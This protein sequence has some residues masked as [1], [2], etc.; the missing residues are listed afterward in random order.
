MQLSSYSQT[1]IPGCGSQEECFKAAENSF[2]T[3]GD[4]GKFFHPLNTSLVEWL[5]YTARSWLYL[6]NAKNALHKINSICSSAE[7]NYSELPDLAN[8]FNAYLLQ[9]ASDIDNANRIAIAVLYSQ[10]KAFEAN[11]IKLMQEEPL[12]KDFTYFQS[13]LNHLA[14]GKQAENNF[15]SVYVNNAEKFQGLVAGTGFRQ[16]YASE[17]SFS[18]LFPQFSSGILGSMD[19]GA[20]IFPFIRS[21]L[22]GF[23]GFVYSSN[24][25]DESLE[26]MKKAP[27]F[28][29]F[30]AMDALA[31]TGNS[32]A[33]E[34]ASAIKS[35]ALNIKS[36]NEKAGS[37]ESGITESISSI[38][39]SLSL[40][41]INEG[42]FD[43]AFVSFLFEGVQEEST[44]GLQGFK[45]NSLP[46]LKE[47]LQ[48]ELKNIEKEFN[49]LREEDASGSLSLGRKLSGFKRIQSELDALAKNVSFASNGLSDG[50][51]GLCESKSSMIKAS[52]PDVNAG[53]IQLLY[54]KQALQKKL[55]QFDSAVESNKLGSCREFATAFSSLEKASKDFLVFRQESE[56]QADD[57]IGFLEKVFSAADASFLNQDF[58]ALKADESLF[59]RPFAFNEGC[60]ELKEKTV[61]FLSSKESVKQLE[62]G[63]LKAKALFASMNL[64]IESGEADSFS[65]LKEFFPDGSFDLSNYSRI[66]SVSQLLALF[67]EKLSLKA[68]SLIGK[69]PG[70]IKAVQAD[71]GNGV[72]GSG[73]DFFLEIMNPFKAVEEQFT[74]KV[75]F[76]LNAKLL[77]KPDYVS[78]FEAC[79]KSCLEGG[80]SSQEQE[81]ECLPV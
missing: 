57:C 6:N 61:S 33:K 5:N 15:I 54:L 12:A 16:A 50:V 2:F 71:S 74:M 66:G 14:S 78:S 4:A 60:L 49:S 67:N 35:T 51:I 21:A 1:S 70:L 55:R 11:D 52:L 38:S 48:A 13:N 79:Q 47:R 46:S 80:A 77:S 17:Q 20:F 39:K 27:A 22:T 42:L 3:S 25:L 58:L 8:V 45:V 32:S 29:F 72:E 7:G 44:L 76:P 30:T 68:V 59:S 36:A 19:K 63:F 75:P 23:I 26:V 41:S 56:T 62:A 81:S 65:T 69:S 43:E 18:D 31:G 73:N 24:K 9:S 53:S 28:S 34:F 64:G 37:L 40:L 10:S